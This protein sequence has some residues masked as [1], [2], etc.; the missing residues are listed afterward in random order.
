[1]SIR[2]G[3]KRLTWTFVVADVDF[4]ILGADVL[5]HHNLLVD[6]RRRRLVDPT[7]FECF[8]T[9]RLDNVVDDAI[10]AHHVCR[11]G[12]A[13]QRRARGLP[14]CHMAGSFQRYTKA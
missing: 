6:M 3:S 13:L 2:I 12:L 4:N 7:T 11:Q 1:M 10:G 5:A 14:V 8:R 9:D